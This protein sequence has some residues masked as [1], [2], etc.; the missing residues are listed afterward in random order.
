MNIYGFNFDQVKNFAKNFLIFYI[1]FY[2]NF[3]SNW[4]FKCSDIAEL[5]IAFEVSILFFWLIVEMFSYTLWNMLFNSSF[6]VPR[7]FTSKTFWT[8]AFTRLNHVFMFVRCD[9]FTF[10]T[11]NRTWCKNNSRFSSTIY[12]FPVISL[13]FFQ[14]ESIFH[15]HKAKLKFIK[16][17]T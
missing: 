10:R 8:T 15:L 3:S 14:S 2:F 4:I 7:C 16:L 9:V 6:K 5:S 13:C 11:Q 17:F 1:S 12:F